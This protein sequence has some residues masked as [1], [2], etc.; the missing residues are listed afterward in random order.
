[1]LGITIT[2]FQLSR[3]SSILGRS[4]QSL[5]LDL[6]HTTSRFLLLL[7]PR[8]A[9]SSCPIVRSSFCQH[10]ELFRE[11]VSNEFRARDVVKAAPP[12]RALVFRDGRLI[13]NERWFWLRL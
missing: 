1:M 4:H 11:A 13:I 3:C 10:S 8:R 7:P 6:C 5:R 2:L 9:L 12:N